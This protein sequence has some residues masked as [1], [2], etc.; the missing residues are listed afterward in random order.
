MTCTGSSLLLVVPELL[1][2]GADPE[3]RRHPVALDQRLEEVHED[4][5]GAGDHR[6]SARPSSP[7]SRST[8]RRRRSP[9]RGCRAARPR[10]ASELLA[11]R[12]ELVAAPWRPRTATRAYTWAISSIGASRWLLARSAQ[13]AEVELAQ[14]PPRPAAAGRRSSSD[15]R[16]TFSVA[17]TVRSATSRADLVDRPAG[18][19]L[20]V[21]TGLLEQLLALGARRLDALRVRA[22]RRP[23]AARVMISSACARASASRSRYSASTCSA[24]LRSFAAASISP[25]R[26]A[27]ACRAPAPIAGNTHLRRIRNEITNTTSTQIISP[28]LGVIRNEP[29]TMR[30]GCVRRWPSAI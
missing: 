28:T 19:G 23:A 13:R 27:R 18:L 25:D 12:V 15:L 16:V 3:D 17:I 5:L 26:V 24:S 9:P 29:L 14:T 4:R 22:P 2:V 11:D 7:R 6:A 30:S 10:T 8:A 1:V 20:D 21:A